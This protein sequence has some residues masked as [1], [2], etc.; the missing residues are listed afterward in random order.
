MNDTLGPQG[1]VP[2]ALLFGEYTALRMLGESSQTKAALD[3]RAIVAKEARHEIEQEMARPRVRC[4]LKQSVSYASNKVL[5]V[6]DRAFVEGE[7]YM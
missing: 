4:S 3:A 7:K 6:G 1:A 5:E 2:S